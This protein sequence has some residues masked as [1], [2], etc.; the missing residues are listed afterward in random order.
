MDC[1][2]ISLKMINLEKREEIISL[3]D[4]YTRLL[5]DKQRMYFEEYYYLDMTL[6]EIASNHNVSRNAVFD[7]IKKTISICDKYE[8]I[9]NLV[10]IKKEINECIDSNDIVF[11]KDRL[12][13]I[14]EE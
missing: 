10:K 2:P 6:Q 9:L 13:K 7:Q 14:I 8:E 4:T 11:I 5:T 1:L 12:N 3:Y